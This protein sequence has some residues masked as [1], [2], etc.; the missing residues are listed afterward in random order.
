DAGSTGNLKKHALLCFGENVVEAAIKGE[1]VKNPDGSIFAAFA[2]AGQRPVNVSHRAHTNPDAR[3][4]MAG[5][6]N[7]DLPNG[8]RVS[9]DIQASFNKCKETTDKL[10]QDYPGMLSYA[11]DAWTSLNHRAFV[12]WTVHLQH[13]GTPL[14]FLL[15]IIEVPEV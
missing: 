4:I 11:T 14:C 12:A 15:D 2:R 13:E 9:R 3:L 7:L 6:P 1:G 10:L 8:R 5:R